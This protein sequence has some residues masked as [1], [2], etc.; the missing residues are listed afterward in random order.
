ME[1]P[2][3]VHKRL[4]SLEGLEIRSV[5]EL[6]IRG[7]DR[8]YSRLF[9]KSGE[10]L[11]LCV[12][13]EE[14]SENNAFA[15]AA[16]LFADIGLNVPAV[17][18][19]H[20]TDRWVLQ[21]DLGDMSLFSALSEKGL[22]ASLLLYRQTIRNAAILH[23]KGLH[24]AQEK[25][26]QPQPPFDQSLLRWES[27]YFLEYLGRQ[28]LKT[29][30]LDA[31]IEKDLDRIRRRLLA[32][33]EV[34]LHRDLQSQ[35]VMVHL[36]NAVLIDFQGARKGPA[37]YDVV[38]LLEDPYVELPERMKRELL[39]LYCEERTPNPAWELEDPDYLATAS[40]RLMQTL[41]AYAFLTLFKERVEFE[42][43]IPRALSRL[44]QTAA[45]GSFLGLE[46]AARKS[47]T[48][49]EARNR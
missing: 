35:N 21:E 15:E 22:E 32:Q 28:Y 47:L 18:S 2:L 49:W 48:L 4:L 1:L 19:H 17:K 42:K 9:L 24:R 3:S 39:T 29:E 6:M 20:L 23:E 43:F 40:Q 37:L 11:I 5:Q 25:G 8:V 7:S 44:Q 31:E 38:S 36:K 16:D 46:K 30:L 13:G 14:R 27:Q 41:G 10:T 12:Y 26:F 33:S 45:D 34:L